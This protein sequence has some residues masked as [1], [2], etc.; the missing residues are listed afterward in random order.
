MSVDFAALVPHWLD[1][2]QARTGS[3][4]AP[5]PPA[6]AS[7][8]DPAYDQ[9]HA[10]G[11]DTA[12][13][14]TQ[15]INDVVKSATGY[16]IALQVG[17]ELAK[18]EWDAGPHGYT[19]TYSDSGVPGYRSGSFLVENWQN[20]FEEKGV[21]HGLGAEPSAGN[22]PSGMQPGDVILMARD[23]GSGGTK[24]HAVI[25]KEVDAEGRPTQVAQS[26]ANGGS[27][28]DDVSYRTWEDYALRCNEKGWV[29]TG[30]GRI[31]DLA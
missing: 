15:Y 6:Q 22:P 24:T 9:L 31:D 12:L 23:D 25:V 16:D 11:Q 10:S 20:F 28:S 8:P 5:K 21:W 13:D 3:A 29:M 30:Y 2:H 26:H 4:A 18:H 17:A 19:I 14:C 1:A 7:A 27:S